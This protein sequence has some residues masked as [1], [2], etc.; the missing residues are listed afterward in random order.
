MLWAAKN[1]ATEELNLELFISIFNADQIIWQVAAKHG[2]KGLLE[3]VWEWGKNGNQIAK[4]TFC[5][6][7]VTVVNLSQDLSKN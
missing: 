1:L 4:I 6:P 2:R 5:V 7:N 3:N